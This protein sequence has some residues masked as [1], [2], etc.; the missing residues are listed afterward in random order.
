MAS[1]QVKSYRKGA[2]CAELIIRFYN[3]NFCQLCAF[4]VLRLS[5]VKRSFYDFIE[6]KSEKIG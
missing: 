2:K 6:F 4:E 5:V 3:K 1:Q